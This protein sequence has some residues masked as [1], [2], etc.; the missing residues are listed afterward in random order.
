VGQ[1]HG[2]RRRGAGTC[3]HDGAEHHQTQDG[4]NRSPGP[5]P[6]HPEEAWGKLMKIDPCPVVVS[7]KDG[8]NHTLFKFRDFLDLV[9]QKMGMDAAKWLETHVNRLEVAADYTTAKVETDLT[10]YEASLDSNKTAF[11]DIQ[12]EVETITAILREKRINRDDISK[13]V[14][15]ICKIIENQI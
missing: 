8:S 5:A 1:A 7:L 15:K 10:S 3:P 14:Q 13:V 2:R 6:A 9:D 11:M 12:T 4:R